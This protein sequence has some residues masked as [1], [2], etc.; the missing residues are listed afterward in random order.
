MIKAPFNFVPLADNVYFPQWASQIS[1]DIP[2]RDGVS[3]TINFRITAQSPIFVRNGHTK[4]DKNNGT[5]VYKSFSKTPDDRFFI[6][7]TSIKG[8]IRNVLEIMSL[9]KMTQT[10]NQ[11]FGIRDLSNGADGTFYRDKIKTENVHCGWLKML[12][13]DNYTL[14]DCGLPGRISAEDI[15]G[16]LGIGLEKFVKHKLNFKDD[17]NRTTKRKYE[18]CGFKSKEDGKKID[19]DFG[20][21]TFS[22]SPDYELREDKSMKVGKRLFVK[23]D[24]DGEDGVLIFTG[25]PGPREQKMKKG[26]LTWVGK[27]FEFVFPIVE[28]NYEPVNKHVVKEFLSI[29]KNSPDYENL[30][31]DKLHNG[32][33][34]PVFFTLDKNVKVE[35]IGL[36]YMFKYPAFNTVH[37]AVSADFIDDDRLDLSECIFG[38]VDSREGALKG[39][40]AF[41]HAMAIGNPRELQEKEYVLSTPHPSYYPLYL[42]DG[43]TWNSGSIKLAGRKRY[44]VRDA[45]MP[46]TA[47]TGDMKSYFKPLDKGSQFEFKV[48]FHNLKQVELGALL[49]A[50]TFHGDSEC[51]HSLGMAKPYGFGKVKIEVIGFDASTY[52]EA[53]EQEMNTF[54]SNSWKSQLNELFAMAKGIPAGRENDFSYMKMSTNTNENEFKAGKDDYANGKQLGTFTQII[55]GNVPIAKYI[56]NVAADC[57][58]V[59]MEEVREKQRQKKEQY[60]SL[61]CK[62]Q[63]LIDSHKFEDAESIL[64]E[65]EKFTVD[66]KEIERLRD[67][68]KAKRENEEA[69]RK[70]MIDT[71][72]ADGDKYFE[73]QK[74]NE[75]L[76]K[77]Q[78]AEKL[79]K[80]GLYDK[81][82]KCK[83]AIKLGERTFDEHLKDAPTSTAGAFIG[84][85][86]EWIK[87]NKPFGKQ[88]LEKVKAKSNEHKDSLKNRDN[89][90]WE[91]EFNKW[92]NTLNINELQ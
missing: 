57:E 46:S 38:T 89:K 45:I 26:K 86:D 84:H 77:Y 27:Y 72:V 55:D 33:S 44:P 6:P 24:D 43:Q 23:F 19:V 63:E 70:A 12:R 49:S 4:D 60:N 35:A 36:S 17:D 10:Q 88:E 8:A 53:F 9:G 30:W 28:D 51:F 50:L 62:A 78:E 64:N 42:G 13:E 58:R 71:L 67:M 54:T 11:S 82:Q 80:P 66:K 59:N 18:M 61:M 92:V 56:G 21:L 47:G 2:F 25:Q 81:I 69:A 90:K 32:E 79:G 39:R 68:I 65:A 14:Q 75:A 29:H 22:F 87:L 7:A 76:E 48:R 31:K 74:Y 5:E 15:D 37:N 16:K 85:I 1:H 83:K 34:I 20:K 41:S 91:K 3:G 40:V 52:L 73:A